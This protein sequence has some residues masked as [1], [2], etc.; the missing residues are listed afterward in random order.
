MTLER[1]EPDKKKRVRNRARGAEM[2]QKDRCVEHLSDG[3]K[4]RDEKTV[5]FSKLPEEANKKEVVAQLFQDKFGSVS[6]IHIQADKKFG[7]VHF[8]EEFSAQECLAAQSVEICGQCVEVK[9]ATLCLTDHAAFPKIDL[10]KAAR[11]GDNQQG[12][13]RSDPD[14]EDQEDRD[15]PDNTNLSEIP[16]EENFQ[17]LCM[18]CIHALESSL[19]GPQLLLH[20]IERDP[21]VVEHKRRLPPGLSFID[22]ILE[23]PENFEVAKQGDDSKLILLSSDADDIDQA[24]I[25]ALL[26]QADLG[27]AL[28]KP[29]PTGKPRMRKNTKKESQRDVQRERPINGKTAPVV[30]ALSD[31]WKQ[32]DERTVWIGQLPP[33]VRGK[34]DIAEALQAQIGPVTHIH[35]VDN[36]SHG[37]VHFEDVHDAQ[38]AVDA[39]FVNILGS[40][41]EV[42]MGESQFSGQARERPHHQIRRRPVPI[43]NA[44]RAPFADRQWSNGANGFNP[45]APMHGHIHAAWQPGRRMHRDLRVLR[46]GLPPQYYQEYYPE[47]LLHGPPPPPNYQENLPPPPAPP[48]PLTHSRFEF[49][50]FDAPSVPPS[51]SGRR[52][53]APC[54]G[55][56]VPQPKLRPTMS[57]HLEDTYPETAYSEKRP[58]SIADKGERPK[59]QRFSVF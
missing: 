9:V 24:K 38:A 37:F 43:A 48:P 12:S 32:C 26:A 40:P 39:K 7:F 23:F 29:A 6:H 44:H 11:Y 50:A 30:P 33:Q 45:R 10:D 19:T 31:G 14:G 1:K 20:E 17:A 53:F 47:H 8:E 13:D 4:A 18:A 3:F 57:P 25:K 51:P 2:R 42:K 35:I 5:W 27:N 15:F 49:D 54:S 46:P 52:H 28:H 58:P 22:F 21:L 16:M 34:H 55:G 36:R 59:R 41:V 56:E